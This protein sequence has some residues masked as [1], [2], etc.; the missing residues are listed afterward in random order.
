MKARGF[1]TIK[2]EEV[3]M[4]PDSWL[5]LFDKDGKVMWQAP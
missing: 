5:V 3:K 1:E 2:T 4:R